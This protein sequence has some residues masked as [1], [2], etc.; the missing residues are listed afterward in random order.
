[1]LSRALRAAQDR[2]TYGVKAARDAALRELD[3]EPGV[4]VDYVAI[5]TPE[6]TE[7]DDRGPEQPAAA[8]ILVAA[9]VGST[10]L[11]DNLP[12]MLGAEVGAATT[13]SAR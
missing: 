7:V 9:R 1:V 6:L 4:E 13:R 3:T 10:R 8:R 2:A 5:R 12:L 11:I